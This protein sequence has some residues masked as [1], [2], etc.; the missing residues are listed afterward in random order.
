MGELLGLLK[1]DLDPE[2]EMGREEYAY[3]LMA[4]AAGIA[5]PECRL[6]E[7]GGGRANFLIRRFDVVERRGWGGIGRGRFWMSCR[8]GSGD[9]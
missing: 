3:A 9:G 4:G 2:L 1:F 5:M 6:L 7:A 8:G